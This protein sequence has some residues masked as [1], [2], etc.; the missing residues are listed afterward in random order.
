MFFHLRSTRNEIR[1]TI[2]TNSALAYY[3]IDAGVTKTSPL[4]SKKERLENW[5]AWSADG[6]YLY[7]CTAPTWE[8]QQDQWPPE[9]Y[10][11]IKYDLVRISYDLDKDTWGQLETVLEAKDTGLSIA[12]PHIS[13]DGRWLLFCMCDYSFFPAWQESSD[14]YMVDLKAAE[15]TGQYKYRRL[16]INSGQSESWQSWSSNSRWIVF[17]SKRGYGRFTKL[18]FSYVDKSGRV[19]KPVLL[20]QKDPE[21]YNRRLSTYS[22]PEFITGPVKHVRG[23]LARAY[24]GSDKINVAM[25]ITMATPGKDGIPRQELMYGERE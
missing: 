11:E 21:F 23:E 6:K 9:W 22:V 19:Y 8:T 13:P 15:Q 4:F 3:L 12:M 24:R 17:S 10:D 2:E 14:L 25:P 1:D 7:F 20:P 5:P 18:Y 16:E